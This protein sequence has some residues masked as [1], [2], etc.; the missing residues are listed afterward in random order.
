MDIAKVTSGSIANSDDCRPCD[1]KAEFNRQ[2]NASSAV[3]IVVGSNTKSRTAGSGCKR[4]RKDI[5]VSTD[6]P[7]IS[8]TVV[9]P[10]HAKVIVLLHKGLMMILDT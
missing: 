10:K 7:L 1:L 5:S 8:R 9:V 4:N 6:A 2:I 3:I